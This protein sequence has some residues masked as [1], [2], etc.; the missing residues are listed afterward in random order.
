[1]FSDKKKKEKMAINLLPSR[2]LPSIVLAIAQ[3]S[4]HAHGRLPIRC[5]SSREFRPRSTIATTGDS[6]VERGQMSSDGNYYGFG[7]Y[8]IDSKEVFYLT[9]LS[10]AMVNL[11]PILPGHVLICPRREVKRFGDLTAEETIDLWL[12]AKK[13]GT[14]LECFHK[15]TSLTFTIQV[16]WFS[17]SLNRLFCLM[18]LIS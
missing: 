13:V 7:P 5:C 16:R 9:N 17:D 10:F 6:A 2:G 12:T 18:K 15:A 3:A 11:R 14:Q 1:M 8:R 4:R